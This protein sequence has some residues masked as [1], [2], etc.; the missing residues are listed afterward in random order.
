MRLC[1]LLRAV[2]FF[3]AP[4]CGS[5]KSEPMCLVRLN[6]GRQPNAPNRFRPD[7]SPFKRFVVSFPRK[8]FCQH[9]PY[10]RGE[11]NA[12]AKIGFDSEISSR[13]SAGPLGRVGSDGLGNTNGRPRGR[14]RIP[15]GRFRFRRGERVQGF[16]YPINQ[17]RFRPPRRGAKTPARLFEYTEDVAP[18]LQRLRPFQAQYLQDAQ[19]ALDGLQDLPRLDEQLRQTQPGVQVAGIQRGRPAE[20][21]RRRLGLAL[22]LVELT[23]VRPGGGQVFIDLERLVEGGLRLIGPALVRLAKT[24]VAPRGASSAS[25]SRQRP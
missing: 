1:Y 22:L 23:Q 19:A 2:P 12:L 7:S 9:F 16:Q 15:G 11:R 24:Q 20:R 21:Q 10:R 25:V 8:C 6:F 5:F 13:H 14:R 4:E 17:G 3:P 18:V